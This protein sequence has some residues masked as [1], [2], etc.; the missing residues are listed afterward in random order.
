MSLALT[1]QA[2]ERIQFPAGYEDK[3]LNYLSLDRTQ[4]DD[5]VIR[6]FAT[7]ETLAAAQAGQELCPM[8]RCL[9]PNSTRPRK[10]PMAKSLKAP[11]ADVSAA[12][13]RLSR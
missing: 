3:M 11:S 7:K 5:Q 9:S 4:N 8:A 12:N 10:T 6:L 2:E 1:V 13:S